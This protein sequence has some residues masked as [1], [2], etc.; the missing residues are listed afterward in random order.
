MSS[1]LERLDVKRKT[2]QELFHISSRPVG[3]NLLSFWQWSASNLASNALRGVLAEYIVAC[4]IGVAGGVRTEWDAYDLRT[5]DGLKV[6]VKSAAYLQSWKQ[7]T[8]SR[9]CFDIRPTYGWDAATNTTSLERKRQADVYV[10][11]LLAHSD[12]G[13]LDPMDLAQW[14]FFVL[15]PRVLDERMPTQKTISMAGLLRLGPVKVELRSI[16]RMIQEIDSD[17]GR[18]V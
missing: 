6:E 13:T 10:F 12:K 7:T 1:Q 5:L 9:I 14:E 3:F 2:G 17:C 16:G 15:P 18:H 8:P 4:A 11:C